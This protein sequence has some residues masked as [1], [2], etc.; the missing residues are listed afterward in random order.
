MSRRS[1]QTKNEPVLLDLIHANEVEVNEFFLFH[2]NKNVQGIWINGSRFPLKNI[3]AE[4]KSIFRTSEYT[5][6][7]G[8]KFPCVRGKEI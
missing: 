2:F 1:Q 7:G 3:P 8:C 5:V 4:T 6:T